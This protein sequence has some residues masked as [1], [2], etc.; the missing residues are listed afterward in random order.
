MIEVVIKRDGSKEA[1]NAGKLNKWA[2]WASSNLGDFVDWPSVAM[3]AVS[4]LGKECTSKQL[5]ERL[6]RVCLDNDSWSY[7][8]M[9]GRLLAAILNKEIFPE[10]KPTVQGLHKSLV[11]RG[12][13]VDLGYT[14]SEYAAIEDIIDH[15]LDFNCVY[16]GL[17]F[18]NGKYANKD[19]TKNEVYETT[20]FV[21]MRMA[22]ALSKDEV[23]KVK[24]VSEWYKLFSENVIN[25]PTPNYV[26]LGTKL[27][28]LSSCCVYTTNDTWP[29]LAAGNHIDYV[30]T[31]MSSG[32]GSH[33]K[34]RSVGDGVRSG[35]I[36]HMGKLP[37]Y[38]A[39][40]GAV[41]AN[42]QA[43]RGGAATVYYTC[44]DPEV[45]DL[46]QLRNPRQTEDKRIRGLHYNMGSN[47]TFARAVAKNEDVFGF[48]YKD[49]PELY[50]AQYEGD[51]TNFEQLY[52]KYS[53]TRKAAKYKINAREVLVTSLTE[54]FETGTA[55]LH[56]TDEMN[57]HT[58]FKDKI[59]SSN[60]CVAPETMVLTRN[61][62]VPIVELEDCNTDIWNGEE[63]SE[64]CPKKTGV[65][66]KLLKVTTSA[67]QVLECTE[68]HKWYVFRD[69]GKPF[70]EKRTYQLLEG[71]KLIKFDLPI[72]EGGKDLDYAYDNGFF[73]GDGSHSGG[74]PIIYLYHSKRDLKDKFK[75]VISWYDQPAQER[76]VGRT[77][78]LK[79]KF[80]VPTNEYSVK[81]RLAWLSGYL[82]ADGCIY[83]NG[84]NEA[85][86]AC[87][88]DF[89]FLQ[90]VQLML[91]TLGVSCKISKM[92]DAGVTQ[93][94]ANDGTGLNKDFY[95]QESYRLLLTSYDS[96]K[97][98]SLG[99]ETHRL[100]IKLRRPQRDAKQFNKVVSVVDEGRFD[101]TYCF[102]ESKRGM[103]VFN[104][105]LTGNCVE[106]A[107]P[108]KGYSGVEELYS[109]VFLHSEDGLGKQE[110]EIG[111]C[112]LAAINVANIKNDA[113]YAKAAYYALKMIDKC[114]HMSD[115]AFPHLELTAK[116]RMN[117]GVGIVG[118][119]HYMAKNKKFYSSQEGKDKIHEL[120][121]T[122]S[123]HVIN[124]SLRLGKE[125][126]NAPW[127]GRTKWPDGWL[128]I[129]TYNKSVDEVVTV[130]LQRDWEGL[131]KAI[132]DN[133]GIRNSCLVN[134]MPSESSSKA[135]QTTNSVYPV[136]DLTLIK[137]DASVNT[138]WAAPDG[139]KLKKWYE[140]AWDIETKD[141]IDVYAII[142]KFTDQ[143]ISADLYRKLIGDETVTT[144]EMIRDY[145]RMVKM[146]MKTRYYQNT[147]TSNGTELDVGDTGCA[148]GVCTL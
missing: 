95:C 81:A 116:A 49:S 36:K 99:L 13:M 59:Y 100:K 115:F 10:G 89:S 68:Y 140:F 133:G 38:R 12:L 117:A 25:A 41:Q 70:V 6:I 19:R 26:N 84:A 128:P 50:E 109:P 137:T 33:I 34:T 21:Y 48:S 32:I 24:E 85:I 40:Q 35:A 31:C 7:Y 44:Y 125:M 82:D 123:W 62:Y 42:M 119:A 121:E 131:R 39:I 54:A 23:D 111:L 60:L 77:R 22:M 102:T 86:T 75:S 110:P 61:G 103:G 28:G 8:K 98:V 93:L 147:K 106:T 90:E 122:H 43:G 132:V 9:A 5:Q 65:N 142:Q 56:F 83:R 76:S 55:Y 101:D 138:L 118:L 87:S 143:S 18:I 4:T 144:Q 73:S 79:D 120:A 46:L 57:R 37:Y 2:E 51:Q 91:Q 78:L 15:D 108:T 52:D 126:G 3:Q 72:I 96:F 104:G 20:Q 114:I 136:R 105:I 88:V 74:V 66:Q 67:G 53:K 139:D 146:G 92:R 64:V 29:S 80:F 145:L 14:D 11:K 134:H 16:F 1:F 107:F 124:A 27:N 30:M 148:G 94:P 58:P 63:W 112:S 130:G 97:L 129:D 113:H 47:K 71:D 127:M 69:Y 45:L 141:M 135:S 17:D